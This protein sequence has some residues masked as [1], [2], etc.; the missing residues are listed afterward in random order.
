MKEIFK[1]YKGQ[2]SISN[3]GNI[4]NNKTNKILKLRTNHR[5]YLKTNISINGEKYTV[6]PHRMVAEIFILNSE[7]K[8]QVNHIDGNKLNNKVDNLEWCTCKENVQHAF[9]NGL[10]LGNGKTVYQLNNNGQVLNTFKSC[11]DAE[12]HIGCNGKCIGVWRACN[13]QRK[14]HKGWYWSY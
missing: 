11:R 3:F 14:S 12:L 8:P 1:K 9:K 13:K 5:G 10:N 7:N 4:R 6:F 2:Y